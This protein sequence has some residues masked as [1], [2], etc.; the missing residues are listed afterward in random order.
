MMVLQSGYWYLRREKN[1]IVILPSGSG[2]DDSKAL[3]T[4]LDLMIITT[5]PWTTVC[6]EM[7]LTFPIHGNLFSTH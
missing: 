3:V 5:A 6:T 4:S 1:K 2:G 7:V